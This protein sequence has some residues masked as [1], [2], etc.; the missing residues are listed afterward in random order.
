VGRVVI[1]LGLVFCS[2][3]PQL[4]AEASVED[5]EL[6]LMS[7]QHGRLEGSRIDALERELHV[8][9]HYGSDGGHPNSRLDKMEKRIEAIEDELASMR[10]QRAL[11]V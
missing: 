8:P 9:S 7:I 5:I 3:L 1:L 4:F 6:E 11:Q 10:K 2:V